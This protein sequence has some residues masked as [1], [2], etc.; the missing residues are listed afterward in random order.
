[1]FTQ[2]MFSDAE[3]SGTSW[4]GAAPVGS[5]SQELFPMYSLEACPGPY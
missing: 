1:M 3:A 2:V 5:Q 4:L